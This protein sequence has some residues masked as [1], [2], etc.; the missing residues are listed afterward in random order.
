MTSLQIKGLQ[1][2]SL[3]DYAPYTSCVLFIAGCN[4]KCPF[5]Q[6]P[7]LVLNNG[8]LKT[9][10]ESEV[11]EFLKK[12]KKWLDG[13]CITGGEPCLY[14][15][16]PELIR[17]IK[18]IGY[19]VKLDTNGTNPLMLKELIDKK[20]VDYIAMDIKGPLERY[21]EIANAKVDNEKIEESAKILVKSGVDYE[22]RM[23]IT[24]KL[25]SENDLIK[26]GKWLKGGRRFFIQQFSNKICLD[27]SYEKETPYSKEKLI[28]FKKMLE[29]YFEE[30]GVRGV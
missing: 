25:I 6:N 29:H 4:F 22:F 24:P 9:I 23:T 30:V 7:E 11:L 1:K 26:T 18:K 19:K 5:C 13:V 16:L 27:K 21:S 12:R 8:R 15:E 17:K 20:L 28:E 14:D 3:I 2:I 10:K